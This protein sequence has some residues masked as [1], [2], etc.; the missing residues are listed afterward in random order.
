MKSRA[1]VLLVPMALVVF[2]AFASSAPAATS[3]VP[4]SSIGSGPGSG[5]SEF[6]Q[7]QR[8]AVDRG[9]GDVYVV[10]AGNDRV[11]VF[12]ASGAYLT[13]IGGLDEPFGIAI[14]QSASPIS[15]YVA[16]AGNL[17]IA[18]LDSD[19][20]ATPSFTLDASFVIPA[21]A[22]A[23]KVGDFHAPLAVDPANGDLF[24]ADRADNQ[25]QRYSADGTFEDAAN[26]ADS[27][28]GAF[29]HLEDVAIG[30]GH[31]Y[32][33]D[34]RGGAAG[35]GNPSRV[36]QLSLGGDFE[37]T[38]RPLTEEGQGDGLVAV[39][40]N[41]GNVLVGDVRGFS[42]NVHVFDSTG[43]RLTTRSVASPLG[44]SPTRLT[45]LAVDGSTTEAL[46]AA[47]DDL[48]EGACG[49]IAVQVLA[50]AELP[51]ATVDPVAIFDTS[52]ATF[53]GSVDPNGGAN[54][55]ASFEYSSDGE[56]WNPLPGHDQA[57]DPGLDGGATP[58]V[59][60]DTATGLAQNTTYSVRLSA[61]GPAGQVFSPAQQ[62]TTA[63]VPAPEATI[64]PVVVDGLDA[65]FSGT[66]DPKGFATEYKFEF[67]VDDGSPDWESFG[68]GSSSS[69]VPTTVE[70]ER[71]DLQAQTDYLVRLVATNSGGSATSN[72]QSFSTA[73]AAPL[74][75]AIAGSER[76]TST[77]RISGL[78]NPHGQ[79]TTYYFEYGS[80]TGYGSRFPVAD[81]IDVGA[82]NELVRVSRLLTGIAP[83]DT[84]HYRLVASNLTGT[85]TSADQTVSA[86][87]A[88]RGMELVSP[89]EKSGSEVAPKFTIQASADGERVAYASNGSFPGSTSTSTINFF[90]GTRTTDWN[91]TPLNPP[92]FWPQGLMTLPLKALSEDLTESFSYSM[93]ALDA[94]A[95]KGDV[96]AYIGNT[97]GQ[98]FH[99][100]GRS[101][102]IERNAAFDSR[103]VVGTSEDFSHVVFAPFQSNGKFLPEGAPNG[104]VYEVFDGQLRLVSVLPDGTPSEGA[105]AGSSLNLRLPG[106]VSADG[107]RIFWASAVRMRAPLYVRENGTLTR[108]ITVSRRPGDPDTPESG[109]F[110]AATPS[111]RYVFFFS[112]AP[113]TV[114]AP[115]DG[116][117][118]LYRLD[119]DTDELVTI[120]TGPATGDPFLTE[121]RVWGIA[122]DGSSAYFNSTRALTPDAVAGNSNTYY[123]SEADG[124][125]LVMTGFNSAPLGAP[126][127]FLGW[128]PRVSPDGR[129]LAFATRLPLN[130]YDPALNCVKAD[131]SACAMVY[132]FDGKTGELA[133]ASCPPDGGSTRGLTSMGGAGNDM[134]ELHGT[135]NTLPHIQRAAFDDGSIF[136]NSADQLVPEDQDGTSDVYGWRAGQLDLVTRGTSKPSMFGDASADGDA[137]FFATA[138]RLV[139]IDRDDNVD[140]YAARIGG[141]MA[142]QNPQPDNPCEGNA[143]LAPPAS[144]PAD[145]P[146]ASNRVTGKAAPPKCRVAKRNKA[147]KRR[148][149]Q[150]Q[151]GAKAQRKKTGKA[152]TC[153]RGAATR[154]G[155]R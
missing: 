40:P 70:S 80:D 120:T 13:E 85:T 131:T 73:A 118:V 151:Q 139:G 77:V 30:N 152:K 18:K 141:G 23:S 96:N 7:S 128:T 48:C 66:V 95:V 101:T 76:T 89:P 82:G 135:F 136:F 60:T 148:K 119:L 132:V 38:L 107:S 116:F 71:H 17:R 99:L 98:H 45:G 50:P 52:S 34:A 25:I 83:G 105:G 21:G 65:E 4:D 28:D 31:L 109:Y 121:P 26:G 115:T 81:G 9:S 64:H 110:G 55:T 108:A 29:A 127:G 69:A 33:V 117:P 113:L 125:E 35:D 61:N 53:T 67:A 16:D 5:Q 147:G 146:P 32:V 92:L 68:Q 36:L 88:E 8:I 133:C 11:Q 93:A 149:A 153:R 124:F 126:E 129:Y 143:C 15:V 12:S 10:D 84:V 43:Q 44:E 144:P 155:S 87:T 142:S 56:N 51:D 103:P 104:S 49:P 1:K 3:Y 6:A 20:A 37:Q 111:G 86:T 138:E 47:G 72:E 154:G 58:V 27:P 78:V 63:A 42:A 75:V 130:G 112:K 57:S 54:T 41:N 19:G 2:L 97:L 22:G 79:A 59:L 24:V 90:M 102:D 94:S 39:D 106:E 123:W 100:V 91:T 14:D 140:L 150:R 134:G 74:A 137:V 62:F 114:E 145:R 46:Y 122:P